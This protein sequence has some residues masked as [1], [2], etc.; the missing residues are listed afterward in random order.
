MFRLRWPWLFRQHPH[1]VVVSPSQKLE[2]RVRQVER[3]VDQQGRSV[4]DQERRLGLIE[5]ELDVME[6]RRRRMR[7][8]AA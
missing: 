1:G 3:L 7:G 2:P 5:D 8:G 6:G 4:E